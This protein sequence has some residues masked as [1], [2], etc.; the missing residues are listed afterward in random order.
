VEDT[1]A[2]V[3]NFRL[4]RGN[5]KE[6]LYIE[7][8]ERHYCGSPTLGIAHSFPGMIYG[9]SS[10]TPLYPHEVK[11]IAEK[12]LSWVEEKGTEGHEGLPDWSGMPFR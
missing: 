4:D 8:E 6:T 1:R 3:A 11:M 9:Y 2:N 7:L 5:S 12:M 10:I